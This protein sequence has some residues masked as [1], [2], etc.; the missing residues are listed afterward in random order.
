MRKNVCNLIKDRKKK[1]QV[2]KVICILSALKTNNKICKLLVVSFFKL[3]PW[4]EKNVLK[5]CP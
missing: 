3:Q 1:L 5:Y 2:M 4:Q